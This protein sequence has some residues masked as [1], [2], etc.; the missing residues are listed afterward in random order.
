MSPECQGWFKSS[1]SSSAADCV[2]V[3]IVDGDDG[4]EA[5]VRNS[6]R[7]DGPVLVFDRGEWEAF[8][9][10]VFNGEFRMPRQG[11]RVREQT[12]NQ[13]QDSG[14]PRAAGLVR[15]SKKADGSWATTS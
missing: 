13:V 1:F 10:G 11:R 7:P 14:D 5:R 8:E 3:Q 9:L 12:R 15:S 2:E 4:I 6:R